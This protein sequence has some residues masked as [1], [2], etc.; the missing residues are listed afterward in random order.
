MNKINI[1]YKEG[2]NSYTIRIPENFNYF[3]IERCYYFSNEIYDQTHLIYNNGK[4]SI[5][6]YGIIKNDKNNKDY[7]K[8]DYSYSEEEKEQLIKSILINIIK[9][10]GF[11]SLTAIIVDSLGYDVTHL[12]KQIKRKKLQSNSEE[13]N[14]IPNEKENETILNVLDYNCE[15]IATI[16]LKDDNINAEIKTDNCVDIFKISNK[17]LKSKNKPYIKILKK[18][19]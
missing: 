7:N 14:I 13:Y 8:I 18:N 15:Y 19:N 12:M 4:S 9:H 16:T 6:S 5:H 1:E 2:K 17:Y 10:I 11:N 3:V